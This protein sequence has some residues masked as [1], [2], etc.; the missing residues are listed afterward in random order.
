MENINTTSKKYRNLRKQDLIIKTGRGYP[1]T[2]DNL[3]DGFLYFYELNGR[4]PTSQEVD[5]FEFL[6]TAKTIQ[7]S[8]GGLVQLRN[9]LN[10]PIIDYTKGEA[11]A[12]IAKAGDDRARIYEEEFFIFLTTKF[13]EIRVHEHKIIR[14]GNTAADF[15]VYTSKNE[16]VVIDLFYARDIR[17]LQCI[18]NIK[19]KKYKDVTSKVYFI[20]VGNDSIT[21]DQ[22]DRIM[23][24]K[25]VI[26]LDHIR[27]LSGNNF[28]DNI[29][30]FI[31]IK[32]E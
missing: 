31:K 18:V 19:C 29:E 4:Y 15:F 2:L 21:Q 13:D 9:R 17:S 5:L 25:K 8:F 12:K 16:G 3:R 11:R 32:T 20:I 28:K 23:N 27:V 30:K 24:N 26:L 6:P 10:L 7:R 22:I 1:W 14:P